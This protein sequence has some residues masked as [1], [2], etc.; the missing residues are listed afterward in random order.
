MAEKGQLEEALVLL[1]QVVSMLPNR[2]SGYNNRAQL[3]RLMNKTDGSYKPKISVY[4][5]ENI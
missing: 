5:Y 3:K 4:F 1:N 2:A